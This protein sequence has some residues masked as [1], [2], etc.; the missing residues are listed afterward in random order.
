MSMDD[1]EWMDRRI[2]ARPA[3][4]VMA[5]AVLW[6][7]WGC[8][9]AS[10]A[11]M[12]GVA[13]RARV[14]EMAAASDGLAVAGMDG[15][16][17]LTGELRYVGHGQFWG[18]AAADVS[19]ASDPAHADPLPAIVGF[20]EGLAAKGIE[21]LVVPVPPKVVVFP[22]R[23]VEGAEP[24]RMDVPIQAFYSALRAHGVHVIDLT[25]SFLADRLGERGPIYCR[26]DTHW[27]PRACE[28]AA[29]AIAAWIRDR[30]LLPGCA[31]G[32][33][34]VV[35][36]PR[37]IVGD[38]AAGTTEKEVLSAGVVG[39]IPI[40]SDP[41]SPVILMGDSHTLVFSDGLLHGDRAGLADHLSHGL[42]MPLDL[43]F[44]NRGSGSTVV[45]TNLLRQQIRSGRDGED[46]LAG[47]KVV[48]W[49]F[50][51]RELSESTAGWRVLPVSQ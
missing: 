3:V 8:G 28:T 22:D 40:A 6:L 41:A 44:R 37:E 5:A 42:G 30:G 2:P 23:A 9:G 4:V 39:D 29:E 47:K 48:V 38:L 50:A 7:D 27:A 15:W 33:Q 19:R 24:A 10:F 31:P 35:V 20:H 16:L 43:S 21:L 25:D 18:P 49:C 46:Y 45:R 11:A 32:E 1:R 17:F 51:A 36:T 13:F 26:T 34:E 14:A 12:D